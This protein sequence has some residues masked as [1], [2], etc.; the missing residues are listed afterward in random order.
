MMLN[1]PQ[2]RHQDEAASPP[3]PNA[4]AGKETSVFFLR[5]KLLPPRPAPALPPRPR[6]MERLRPNLS[7][8]VTLV[9]ANAGSGKTTLVADFV[10]NLEPQRFVWYQLDQADAD[11]LVFLGYLAHGIR[12]AVPGFGSITLSYLEEARSDLAKRPERALDV[13]L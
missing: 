2:K 8:P 12:Q 9:P 11:P 10:R 6:L 5:T 3:A 1:D 13:L 7:P 4:E